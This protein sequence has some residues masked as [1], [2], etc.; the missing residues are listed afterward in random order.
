MATVRLG[1]D[2]VFV[3]MMVGMLVWAGVRGWR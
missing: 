2:L 1:A 3:A